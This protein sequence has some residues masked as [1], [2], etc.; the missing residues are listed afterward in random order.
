[1]K[2]RIVRA[3]HP[4]VPWPV[5]KFR[6]RTSPDFEF[7]SDTL[8]ECNTEA[9]EI[10]ERMLRNSRIRGVVVYTHNHPFVIT[11]QKK[12]EPNCFVEL[13]DGSVLP[14]ERITH[15]GVTDRSPIHVEHGCDIYKR[16]LPD[17]FT[18]HPSR[19]S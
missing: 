10:F 8:V 5:I 17:A 1:M 11:V 9:Q 18:H 13:Y 7:C 3:T 2:C 14:A 6:Y 12:F 15:P 19:V 4:D 16:V